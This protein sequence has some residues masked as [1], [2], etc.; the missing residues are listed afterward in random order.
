MQLSP[1]ATTLK[2]SGSYERNV[3]QL[4]HVHDL[5]GSSS[6]SQ[7]R[8][9]ADSMQMQRPPTHTATSPKSTLSTG[10]LGLPLLSIFCGVGRKVNATLTQ[11]MNTALPEGTRTS[12]NICWPLQ[13]PARFR[14]QCRSGQALGTVKTFC[15]S[16]LQETQG[17]K[18]GMTGR[19]AL[20]RL[21]TQGGGLTAKGPRP[22]MP[23]KEHVQVQLTE[24]A[25]TLI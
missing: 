11:I 12:R 6:G 21:D 17:I 23:G 20:P 8:V 7:C 13:S 9:Q 22:R 16:T 5:H 10:Q 14:T 25:E 15:C 3:Y 1:R 19:C 24:C 2:S 18:Q 4:S